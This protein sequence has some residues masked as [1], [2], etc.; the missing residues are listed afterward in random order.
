MCGINGLLYNDIHRRVSEDGLNRMRAEQTH[1]GPDDYGVWTSGNVGLAFNRLAIIDL[2][3][4]HQP[5]AT[6][7]ES[8]C[9]VFNGEIYNF[10]ALR[11]ELVSHGHVFRTNSDTEVLLRSWQ[12]WGEDCLCHLRG[13]F[14]FVI[15]DARR[16]VLFGARD[17]LG[18]KP[19][20]YWHGKECF[21]FASELRSLLTLDS[22]PRRIDPVALEEYLNHRY[23]IAPRTIIENVQKLSPAHCFSLCDGSLKI[24][25]YW[26][27]PAASENI[28]E[29]DAVDALAQ[30][31]EETVKLHLESDVPLG[32]FL[33]GGLDSSA[34]VAWMKSAGAGGSINT[35]SIGYDSPESELPFARQVAA[36]CGTNHHEVLLTAADF[37]QSLQDVI[38]FMDEPVADEASLPLYVLCRYARQY[39][40]VALSGE[41][42]D[43]LFAGYGYR[44]HTTIEAWKDGALRKAFW[45]AAAMAPV[46]RL[47]R[48]AREVNVPLEQAYRGVSRIFDRDIARSSLLNPPAQH[49]RSVDDVYDRCPQGGAL[50]RMTFLDINTWLP[51][52]LLVKADRMSMAHS[53][54][55]RVPFL[56]HHVVEFAYKLPSSL[57]VKGDQN[58]Y[59]LKKVAEQILP[60]NIVHRPKKGFPVP[61]A[62]W[63]RKELAS[64]VSET[65]HSSGG[66]TRYIHKDCIEKVL[67]EHR[68]EDRSQQIYALLVFDSWCREFIP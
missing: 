7:D 40:T 28:M 12:Q 22:I 33:S 54:E 39:V 13:M 68:S 52:D 55:L 20:F 67:N 3:G 42:S 65:L 17:R 60:Y 21:A 6:E 18:I 62:S 38:K 43:E 14:A 47:R 61:L 49:S 11:Q 57:K 37:S 51:D 59:I 31:M 1:R 26:D 53:L 30:L 23:V 36:H 50:E 35:F 16:K 34:I 64:F 10:R 25:R 24:R 15:W 56:D 46:H 44:K 58:K 63:F 41:G 5:M 32:A 45:S 19:L 27:L 2:S 4:G 66:C 9:L 29:Q 8:A 48:K